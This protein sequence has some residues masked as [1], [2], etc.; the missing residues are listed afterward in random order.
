MLIA[1]VLF[2]RFILVPL[3]NHTRRFVHTSFLL[4]P[5]W[6]N[7]THVEIDQRTFPFFSIFL[8]LFLRTY[9][10]PFFSNYFYARNLTLQSSFSRKIL[11]LSLSFNITKTRLNENRIQRKRRRSKLQRQSSRSNLHDS[12]VGSGREAKTE[13]EV[14]ALR[15]LSLSLSL[16]LSRSAQFAVD[17][18]QSRNETSHV[19]F[20]RMIYSAVGIRGIALTLCR[21]LLEWTGLPCI[22]SVRALRAS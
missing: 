9:F 14:A 19:R 5:S 20:D 7:W 1:F 18:S 15:P 13:R 12:I 6:S 16:S 3:F 2:L 22:F 10:P 8:F 17:K 4:F 21:P 11:S